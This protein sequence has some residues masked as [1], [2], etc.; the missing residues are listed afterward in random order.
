MAYHV[1]PVKEFLVSPALPPEL[2]RLGE[3][4][5]NFLWSWKQSIRTVFRRLDPALWKE[6]RRNPVLML[7]RVPQET[8]A[9]AAADP[10]YV[11]QYQAACR[12]FD[13][14]MAQQPPAGGIRVA[15]FS[16][17]YGLLE[18]V[19]IYS[20]GLGIL[21]GDY[22]KAASDANFGLVGVGLLYQKGYLEQ[23]LNPDGWQVE[24]YPINDFFTWPVQ[25]AVDGEGNEV[26]VELRLPRGKCYVKV[27]KMQVGRVPLLL[28]DT[29]I[30]QNT[31]EEYRDITD[32]LYGGDAVTR[33]QQEFVLGVGGLRALKALGFEPTVFHM[34][35][36]HS[37]FLALERMRL[38]MQ[39]QGLSWEEA[40]EAARANNVFTT[41]TPVPA[42]IDMFDPGLIYEYFHAYCERNN[43]PFDRFLALGQGGT[44][45]QGDR[46]SMAVLAL[47]TSAYRNA[48]SRLH[49]EV[50]RNMFSRLWPDF[51]VHEV[52]ILPI[53]NGVH[54]PTWIHPD[55][56]ALYDQYLAP[57][58]REQYMD[59]A[60]WAQVK[61]IPD[62]E[63]WEIRRRRKRRLIAFIRER[64]LQRAQ[65]RH[66]PS[67]E[68]KRLS[69]IFDPEVFTIGFARRFA[70][71][72]RAT[73]LFRDIGRLKKILTDAKMPV[74]VVIAGKAHPK[75]TPGKTLIREI[76][77]ITRDPELARHIVFIEDYDIEVGRELVQGVD[78]W[79]NTP[80]RG[81]EACGT[82]GMKA[83]INGTLNLS[84][85]D[86][87]FDEA[88]EVSGGWAIGDRDPYT[89]DLDDVHASSIYSLLETEILPMYYRNREEGVPQAWMK[90]V[91]TS[92]MNLSPTFNC[93]R[94]IRDYIERMYEPAHLA[95]LRAS[96][97]GYR[98]AREKAEW[99]RKVERA[100]PQ[101]SIEDVSGAVGRAIVTGAAIA[102]RALVDLAGLA[103]GDVRVEAVV[104]RVNPDGEL[105]DTTVL[106][107]P[108]LKEQDGKF[109]FGRDFV[110]HQTGRIGYTL[111]ISP[112]RSEDPVTRPC[113]LP[114]KWTVRN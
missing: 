33:I 109:L 75:D 86:G 32:Q 101:V 85:L 28:L 67:T 16:M 81:E 2:S 68:L 113:Y 47:K 1:R 99:N 80:R 78:L 17:E 82:S 18:S 4:A 55:L 98:W 30:P 50:S 49:S 105:Y 64:L 20:G 61:D 15:Y 92:I 108:F 88:Y 79:L 100:W 23:H 104:G 43:V 14:Y 41:H 57:G 46:F 7:G 102:L 52:P 38:L 8:L 65:E 111:R 72:K 90:R 53:T 97:D 27:W 54:L 31:T 35:E 74:Q 21:S 45:E 24:K 87:W 95:G 40:L 73:L 25:P 89:P 63:L 19:S 22:L 69:E 26:L 112:N 36:G 70:T 6:C 84:I 56:A 66:A 91:K 37:A 71:Y 62:E 96:E 107:L 44:E 51:P 29:N 76:I 12:E 34:N 77:Q 9:K 94:M 3:L 5:F 110:P 10:R 13:E 39:E 58:W 60:I 114:V 42:G 103:P 93:Q 11:A 106:S 59:P 83:A 48:V